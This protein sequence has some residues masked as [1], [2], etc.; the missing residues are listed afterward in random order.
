MNISIVNGENLRER[1]DRVVSVAREMSRKLF[2]RD[3][4]GLEGQKY[5]E[6]AIASVYQEICRIEIEDMNAG[7]N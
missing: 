4:V 7:E 2:D 5:L 6:Q 3:S 1:F